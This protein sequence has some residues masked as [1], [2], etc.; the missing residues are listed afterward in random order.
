MLDWL[1]RS[2]PDARRADEL[3]SRQ[4]KLNRGSVDAP[5]APIGR[6][7]FNVLVIVAEFEADE[8]F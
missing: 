8:K 2:L 4:V 3:T 7:P 5:T 6:L 1:A